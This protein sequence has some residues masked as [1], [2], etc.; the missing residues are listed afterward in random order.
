MLVNW[1]LTKNS[2]CSA[3]K[4][5]TGGAYKEKFML[6]Y[7]YSIEYRNVIKYCLW[8]EHNSGD[9]VLSDNGNI[10]MFANLEH[11]NE[12][13][14]IK[15]IH[16]CNENC[17]LKVSDDFDLLNLENILDIW[18]FASDISNTLYSPIWIDCKS[19]DLC[20]IYEKLLW[21]CN[22]DSLTPDK[23]IFIPVFSDKEKKLLKRI[24][25]FSCKYIKTKL[26]LK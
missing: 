15:K 2:E 26:L 1:I 21:G 16:I 22:L 18:N 12:Y 6:F 14:K 4:I 3:L 17:I 7:V 19:R 25:N 24:Y 11:V 9:R 23:E 8:Y 20:N 5:E 10:K 13:G